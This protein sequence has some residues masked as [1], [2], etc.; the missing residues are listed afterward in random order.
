MSG[1]LI[2]TIRYS[3]PISKMCIDA[4]ETM[5]IAGASNGDIFVSLLENGEG[6]TPSFTFKGHVSTIK[7]LSIAG[8]S[9]LLVSGDESGN[10]FVWDLVNKLKIRS[11]NYPG[12]GL[13]FAQ[14][15]IKS[16]FLSNDAPYESYQ[17]PLIRPFQRA[18]ASS[19]ERQ[20]VSCY[21]SDTFTG[22]QA[23]SYSVPP[24]PQPQIK[25]K[26]LADTYRN[27]IGNVFDVINSPIFINK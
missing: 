17:F 15:S 10:I 3:S 8:D 16:P 19:E 21:I 25:L 2:A 22:R 1:D 12:T 14:L 20:D 24:Q 6:S 7:A 13:S 23:S 4:L 27:L 18:L 9:P 11:F 26:E 5:V